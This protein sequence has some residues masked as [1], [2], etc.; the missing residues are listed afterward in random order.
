M[1]RKQLERYSRQMILPGFGARGQGKLLNGKVLVVGAG[2]LGS[3]AGFY[4]AAAG[5]GTIGLV[6]FQKVSL[7]NLQRQIAHTTRDI[8]RAKVKSA[9]ARFKALNPDVR[10]REHK[11]RFTAQNAQSILADY[12]FVLDCTDNFDSKFLIADACHFARKPYSHAGIVGY[13]GQ[14]MTVIPGKTACY[15]C[16][17][18]APP[19]EKS[20]HRQSPVLGCVPAVIGSIQATEAIKFLLGTGELLTNRLL[21]FDALGM[22]FR[23]V[24]LRRNRKCPLCAG[25]EEYPLNTR[26]DA[27]E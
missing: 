11:M 26:K 16:V 20:P 8:G 10:I 1:N 7:S 4:L 17:F 27:K 13:E 6:D 3:P 22:Q 24:K 5:V 18:G 21:V 19:Q 23:T 9:A 15:R 12:D 25:Q 2:G 14:T